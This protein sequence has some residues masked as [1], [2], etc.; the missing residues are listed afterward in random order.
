MPKYKGTIYKVNQTKPYGWISRK[1]VTD[2]E[3]GY[4][5][6]TTTKDIFL[7]ADDYGLPLAVGLVVMFDVEEDS[8]RPG[9]LRASNVSTFAPPPAAID[10]HFDERVVEENPSVPMR[11]C[12]L[13]EMHHRIRDGLSK[14]YGYAVLLVVRHEDDP[15]GFREFRELK[16]PLRNFSFVTFSKP[17]RWRVGLILYERTN[18]VP[19][20]NTSKELESVI[21]HSFFSREGD[22]RWGMTYAVTLPKLDAQGRVALDA[23]RPIFGQYYV[24]S[25]A[26]IASNEVTIEVPAGIFAP[27]PSKAVQAFAN[28]WRS[29]RPYD[30]CDF[31]QRL[32]VMSLVGWLPWLF[33]ETIKRVGQLGVGILLLLFVCKGAFTAIAHAFTPAVRFSLD[34]ESPS[35]E[36]GN[37]I[38]YKPFLNSK[39]TWFLTP[40]MLIVAAILAVIAAALLYFLFWILLGMVTFVLHIVWLRTVLML[41]TF[42]AVFVLT[43]IAISKWQ[44]RR[45]LSALEK[46]RKRA[47]ELA[48]EQAQ[49]EKTMSAA[50]RQALL[51]AQQESVLVCGDAPQVVSLQALP[52]KL[53]TWSMQ[54]SAFKREVC[55][56]FA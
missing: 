33:W 15:R 16:D 5:L 4:V 10:I 17:G 46:Q 18:V 31:R 52:P 24:E 25:A 1:S 34:L 3:D 20:S 22:K 30:E 43:C 8:T 14:G 37:P 49:L 28:Y 53:R 19:G 54:L 7:H 2:L 6:L 40:G 36:N 42:V 41:A 23:L 39:Y 21:N 44:N 51:A 48:R 45:E 26:P 47:R 55:R 11:W 9:A 38:Y 12:F 56:P 27:P 32:I 35:Y 13:P 50:K 29:N